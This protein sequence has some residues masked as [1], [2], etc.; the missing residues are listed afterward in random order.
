MIKFFLKEIGIET[1]RHINFYESETK[2]WSE[3]EL[4]DSIIE[5]DKNSNAMKI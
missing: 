4:R 3:K 2:K 1:L 5:I